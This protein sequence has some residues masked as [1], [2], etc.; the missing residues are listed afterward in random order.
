MIHICRV[1]L[2]ADSARPSQKFNCLFL[3]ISRKGRFPGVTKGSFILKIWNLIDEASQQDRLRYDNGRGRWGVEVDTGGIPVFHECSV[4]P[5]V[6]ADVMPKIRCG[7]W[8]METV[9]SVRSLELSPIMILHFQ[10]VLWPLDHQH[11]SAEFR[12]SPCPRTV[13]LLHR[14]GVPGKGVL[15]ECPLRHLQRRRPRHGG[16]P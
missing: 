1:D 13:P 12:R 14:H 10:V 6:P 16:M 4:D 11:L 15:Q 7:F 9:C 3:Q 2:S 8:H 5:S